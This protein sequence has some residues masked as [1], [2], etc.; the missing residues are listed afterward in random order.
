M[1]YTIEIPEEFRTALL[2]NKV[3]NIWPKLTER[4]W[5]EVLR[6]LLLHSHRSDKS[7]ESELENSYSQGYEDAQSIA[8]DEGYDHGF[9]VGHEM[10]YDEGYEEGLEAGKSD[11]G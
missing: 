4:E 3:D 9:E 1:T 10:G 7:I 5:G 6:I 8:Y 2:T 11:E